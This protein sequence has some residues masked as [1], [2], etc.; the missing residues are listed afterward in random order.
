M[1]Y[2]KLLAH[3]I[4]LSDGKNDD[5]DDHHHHKIKTLNT[6]AWPNVRAYACAY[7][8]IVDIPG[9]GSSKMHFK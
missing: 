8:G 7:T 6:G 5:D 2:T 1:K 3:V 9:P 4:V